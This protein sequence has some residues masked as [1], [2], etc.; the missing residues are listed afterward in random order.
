[1]GLSGFGTYR[2]PSIFFVFR[3]QLFQSWLE[4]FAGGYF[5]FGGTRSDLL[6]FDENQPLGNN[7]YSCRDAKN[8]W[9]VGMPKNV[10]KL[11][12]PFKT[13]FITKT[14]LVNLHNGIRCAG[15][16][17]IFGLNLNIRNTKNHW[18]STNVESLLRFVKVKLNSN[19]TSKKNLSLKISTSRSN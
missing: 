9:S 16:E 11:R 17:P 10:P 1:M 18:N 3:L 7:F 15:L 4:P 12:A 5:R 6:F 14:Q 8:G 13:Q 2:L 19:F